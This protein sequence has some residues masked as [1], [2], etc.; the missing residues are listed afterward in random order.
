MAKLTGT[1]LQR[2]LG[3][4]EP[5]F[6]AYLLYGPDAGLVQE[7]ADLL[8]KLVVADISD[9]FSVA[10]ISERDI[11][12]DPT[13]VSDE[14]AAQSLLGGRRVVRVRG[15]GDRLGAALTDRLPSND[16]DAMLVVEAAE[17]TP[18]SAL[19]KL[20][21]SKDFAVAI[22]CYTDDT[23]ALNQVIDSTLA[24][25]G[26]TADQDARAMLS[27]LLGM[28]RK[29]TRSELAKLVA[30]VGPAASSI[31]AD[32][33]AAVVVDDGSQAVD[34]I[35][36]AALSGH[37]ATATRLYQRAFAEDVGAVPILRSLARTAQRA[38]IVAD[39]MA[40]G[41]GAR[42][43]MK[44]LRPPVFF[45]DNDVFLAVVRRHSTH[46]LQRILAYLLTIETRV[47]STGYPD[48]AIVGQTLI[49]IARQGRR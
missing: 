22:P 49:S 41:S 20:F 47:K 46:G 28:D 40:G 13:C 36:Y 21:E 15:A 30:Y 17:L 38:L 11:L 43:A 5:S 19:R 37:A 23:N 39:L 6:G 18:R 12:E 33:V 4:T 16:I 32:D 26:L 35:S 8:T 45:K 3:A 31:T 34:A 14:I 29:A 24:Q 2:E 44:A 48:G 25:S 10:M 7:R 9:P 27:E 42:D 1:R